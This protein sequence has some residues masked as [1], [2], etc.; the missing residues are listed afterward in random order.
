[1]PAPDENPTGKTVAGKYRVEQ[2]IGEGGMGKVY[3]ATQLMLDKPVVLKVL[4]PDLLSDDRTVARFQR[5]A[6]AASRLNHPNSI[7]IL[8][9]GQAED[10]AMYIAMEYV[11]GKDLHHILSRE[12]PLPEARVAKII[13]QVLSAL[14]DAHSAGVIHRD[15]KPENIMVEQRRGD[16]DFVKVLDFGI[17]KIQ[18][19][20]TEE[21]PALT[22]A[23]FVCGTPEYM[24]PEQAR[25]AKIDHRSDLYAVGVILYQLVSG[26]LPF[27]SESAI[28]FA[29]KH[30]VEQPL[31][32]TKKRPDAKISPAMERLIMRAMSKV[33]EE[34]PQTAEA[35]RAELLAIEKERRAA[36]ARQR[37]T[38]S[39][40]ANSLE[41]EDTRITHGRP[42]APGLMGDQ[43]ESFDPDVIQRMGKKPVVVDT[44][45][46]IVP[47]V[48]APNPTGAAGSGMALKVVTLA[49]VAVALVLAGTYLSQQWGSSR[50]GAHAEGPLADEGAPLEI[51]LD[52]LPEAEIPVERRDAVGSAALETAADAAWAKGQ[53][54]A[55][56]TK[57]QDAF[58]KNPTA[59]LALKLG[60]LQFQRDKL[61]DAQRWWN[62]HLKENAESK[63][64]PY[65]RAVLGG[66]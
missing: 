6:K 57:Y 8:D 37:A 31:P 44:D 20:T 52:K 26:V 16:P 55:A 5:E 63:A 24:S 66:N 27:E 38:P 29:T 41:Q 28:G 18:D 43:T 19:D 48:T 17:A 32:P 1:M 15:L 23:G 58:V 10:G 40:M 45:K 51:A 2:Q 9:F 33:P 35:F 50:G 12:W 36:P 14:A 34:R 47:E 3:K 56:V 49:L 11:H 21:G 64:A 39:A 65:I 59:G 4:R 13:S 46:N 7:S 25:G 42:L 53:Y 22:K 30:L 54:D 61:K 62:R 60:E